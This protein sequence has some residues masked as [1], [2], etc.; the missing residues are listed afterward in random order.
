MGFEMSYLALPHDCGLI[1]L[2]RSRPDVAED[3]AMLPYWF[4]RAPRR[5]APGNEAVRDT[6][7][8]AWSCDLAARYP[9]LGTLSCDLDRRWDI[10]HDLLSAT[11]RG[12]PA[13]PR[14]H[15][16]DRAFN[17]GELISEYARAGQGVPVRY[18]DRESARQVAAAV[19][20]LRHADLRTH[21]EP[22]RMEAN[23]VYKFWADRMD[24]AEWRRVESYFDAFRAFFL[25]IAAAGSAVVI[26]RD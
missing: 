4:T 5:P 9:S 10:L 6:P 12:E 11:R 8:W 23:G 20:P 16:I 14:D 15:A 17:A 3:V 2:A 22:R 26:V 1:E 13:S 19:G 7:L 25:A 24:D 21:F 18:L